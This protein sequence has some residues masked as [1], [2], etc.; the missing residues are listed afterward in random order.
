MKEMAVR[1]DYLW[2]GSGRPDPEIRRLE[3]VLGRMRHQGP[4]PIFPAVERVWPRRWSLPRAARFAAVAATVIIVA[5]LVSFWRNGSTSEQTSWEVI[6]TAGSPSIASRAMGSAHGKLG[7]GQTLETNAHSQASLAATDI[8]QVDLEPQTRLRV[9]ETRPGRSRLALER[10]TI[11]ASIWSPPGQFAVDTP[12]AIAV[13]LGCRYTLQ[14]DDSGAGLLRTTFGW[15]GFKLRDRESFI[16][17]GAACATRPKIGPGTP[18]FEDA[19]QTFQQALTQLDFEPLSAEQRRTALS[20]VLAEARARDALT[21]WHLLSRSNQSERGL[22]YDR[23]A[24]LEPPP[25]GVTKQ[26]ILSL[27]PNMLDLWWNQLGFG[28]AAWW[29]IWE[30]SW[31]ERK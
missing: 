16:P 11:H 20:V 18:Y 13:D 9:V 2:D 22:I 23:L 15:V 4:A 6:A 21:L 5:G 14:V 1:D 26:G 10:G 19:S 27:N 30:R 25:A 12:S 17:E 8:G 31:S 29:R 7:V 28:D 24:A 3:E